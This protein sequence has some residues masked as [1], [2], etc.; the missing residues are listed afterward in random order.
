[1]QSYGVSSCAEKSFGPPLPSRVLDD[2]KVAS[3][4]ETVTL[5]S[6]EFEFSIYGVKCPDE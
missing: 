2:K 4:S 1:M 6:Y 3:P 5:V